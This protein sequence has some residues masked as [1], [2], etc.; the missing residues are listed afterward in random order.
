MFHF[1]ILRSRNVRL[2]SRR[3][4]SRPAAQ[5]VLCAAIALGVLGLAGGTA[6]AVGEG[7]SPLGPCSW[8]LRS[9]PDTINLA[10]PDT[11][12]YYWSAKFS[13]V[14]GTKLVIHGSYPTARYF[15]FHVYSASAVALDSLYDAQ[16][17]PD[18]GS[19]N[20][21]RT[22]PKAGSGNGYTAEVQ[23]TEPAASR[24]PNTLYA[25]TTPQGLPNASGTLMY[26]VYVPQNP[27]DPAGGV[28]LPRI[29]LETTSGQ[30]LV[31]YGACSSDAPDAGG[32]VN[33]LI[34]ESDY[35]DDVPALPTP[36]ATSPPTWA[37]AFPNKYYGL[38][39]NSQNAYLTAS[40]TREFGNVVVIHA[41]APTFANTRAGQ[42]VYAKR[43]V[44]YWSVCENNE[45]T[46]VIGCAADY[47][48]ALRRGYYTYVISDPD[49]R[50]ANATAAN[51]VTWL[52]WGGTFSNGVLIIRNMLPAPSFANAI[53]NITETSSPRQVMGPYYPTTVYCPKATFEAG[54]WKACSNQP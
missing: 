46:R 7:G 29:S 22:H 50:P 21:Y 10:Y 31:E 13:A 42:P 37:R 25:G 6:P 8:G 16:L 32:G 19:S 27:A 38:F 51:G 17:N 28:P 20:P 23:F 2:S 43:Q 48:A 44:R 26:R 14:P 36:N 18:G 12:A 11:D 40:V 49:Q 52:P 9:N 24:T 33:S 30:T 4:R 41:K 35:P 54:G 1:T 39:G 45:S 53:Q 5:K 47:S 3:P 15:S 34:A